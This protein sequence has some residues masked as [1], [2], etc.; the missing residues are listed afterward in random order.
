MKEGR[1][2]EFEDDYFYL[3]NF[4]LSWLPTKAERET[5]HCQRNHLPEESR[6]V[7]GGSQSQPLHALKLTWCQLLAYCLSAP[8]PFPALLGDA[9]VGAL[10]TAFPFCWL[11]SC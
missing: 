10:Q 5:K 11:D 4:N 8:A 3:T 9:E 7:A 1:V 2:C 6:Y